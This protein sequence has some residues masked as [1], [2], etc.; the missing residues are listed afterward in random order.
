MDSKKLDILLRSTAV[1]LRLG[2]KSVTMDDLARELG[3]S[4]KT[5]YRFFKD[6]NELVVAIIREKVNKD[7]EVASCV[8]GGQVNAIEEMFQISE[9]ITEELKNVTPTVFFD[10][11]K[12]HPEAW[13]I[14]EKH[15]WE[16]VRSLI[17][18]NIERGIAE[19]LYR[20]NCDAEILSIMYVVGTDFISNTHLF[21]WPTYKFQDVYMQMIQQHL[22]GLSNTKGREYLKQ[23]LKNEYND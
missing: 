5:I 16:F 19:G 22:F 20:K 23:K 1:F 18:S 9:F 12:Y 4:K 21:P 7:C 14:L 10:L 15:K 17:K 3:M 8:Q 11:K 13:E 2:I 6:K